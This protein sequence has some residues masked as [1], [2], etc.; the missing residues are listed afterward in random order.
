MGQLHIRLGEFLVDPLNCKEAHRYCSHGSFALQIVTL[1]CI[2]FLYPI[3]KAGV[4]FPIVTVLVGPRGLLPS[5]F[6][7][8]VLFQ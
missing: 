4:C 6:C 2:H 7:L 8:V 5:I 3:K 1:N